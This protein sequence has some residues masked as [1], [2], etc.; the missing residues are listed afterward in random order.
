VFSWGELLDDSATMPEARS[1]FM[2]KG[3]SDWVL[4]F[5]ELLQLWCERFGPKIPKAKRLNNVVY[6]D[7]PPITVAASYWE[8][9]II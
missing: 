4:T 1:F 2:A 5:D 3:E 7:F 6:A 8:T 9:A